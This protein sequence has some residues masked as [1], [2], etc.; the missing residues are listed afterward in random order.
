MSPW[1]RVFAFSSVLAVAACKDD[2]SIISSRTLAGQLAYAGDGR[3][4]KLSKTYTFLSD[5]T[6]VLETIYSALPGSAK[7]PL[8]GDVA[9][10]KWDTASRDLILVR[11]HSRRPGAPDDPWVSVTK[12]EAKLSADGKQLVLAGEDGDCPTG[13]CTRTYTRQ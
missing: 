5:G 6:F 3:T 11:E 7:E 1:A 13:N 4:M 8:P 12:V 2:V 10:G 9:T